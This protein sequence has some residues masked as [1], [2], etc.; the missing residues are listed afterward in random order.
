MWISFVI[1]KKNNE[2]HKLI[3]KNK[4]TLLFS[5]ILLL[6][7]EK[8]M[9]KPK[10]KKYFGKNALTELLISFEEHLILID[11]KS[12]VEICRD[13]KDNFLLNLTIDGKAD[14][15]IT[16]DNDLLI[17]EKIEKTKIVTFSDFINLI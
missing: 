15:L 8:T 2:I 6:E 12:N 17:L 7:I 5:D 14:F 10:L 3:A 1:S 11:V 16:G 9:Q 13:L 4:I